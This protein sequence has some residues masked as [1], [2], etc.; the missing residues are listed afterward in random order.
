MLR[1]RRHRFPLV[2][3]ARRL[4]PLRAPRW[5]KISSFPTPSSALLLHEAPGG[6][7]PSASGVASLKEES[8]RRDFGKNEVTDTSATEG[9]R[10]KSNPTL[11][12]WLDPI[13]ASPIG[14]IHRW[15]DPF[16]PITLLASHPEAPGIGRA[17]P[18]RHLA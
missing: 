18:I 3:S 17:D 11:R 4:V 12:D 16:S 1:L 8:G 2:G 10:G 14:H 6:Y 13:V 15:E 9:K 7:R 5:A